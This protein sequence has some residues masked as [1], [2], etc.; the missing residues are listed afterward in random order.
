M[1]RN[2]TPAVSSTEANKVVLTVSYWWVVQRLICVLNSLPPS[3]PPSL[4]PSLFPSLPPSL[5]PSPCFPVNSPEPPTGKISFTTVT[6]RDNSIEV[7]WEVDVATVNDEIEKL[8]L[9]IQ[10][11]NENGAILLTNNYTV[12]NPSVT[13]SL[14]AG[15]LESKTRYQI[16]LVG[17]FKLGTE[18]ECLQRTTTDDVGNDPSGCLEPNSTKLEQQGED[19][20]SESSAGVCVCVCVRLHQHDQLP[21]FE[22]L[23]HS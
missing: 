20:S 17:K 14:C 18:T 13:K 4:P 12:P 8:T 21:L 23:A 9:R 5:P 6:P 7:S 15:K 1:S 2:C 19:S 16:C 10:K 11:L 22:S 3:F